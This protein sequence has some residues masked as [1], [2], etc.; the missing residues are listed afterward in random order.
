MS[1]G[2]SDEDADVEHLHAEGRESRERRLFVRL[3][4]LATSFVREAQ[5]R[6]AAVGRHDGE[7]EPVSCIFMEDE[8]MSIF[9]GLSE[10]NLADSVIDPKRLF[11]ALPRP[12]GSPF[13]FPHDIQTEVW[14][15]WFPRRDEPDLVVKMNTGSGK[16]VIGLVICR[17][18]LNEGVGPVA[19]LVPN[20]QLKEQVSSTATLLGIDW[21]GEPSDP[22]F[23]SGE[24]LLIDTVH[25]IFHGRTRFGLRGDTRQPLELGSVVIDDAHACIP[26]IEGQYSFT[27]D[28]TAAAYRQLRELFADVLT[29]QSVVGAANLVSGE[30]SQAVPVPYWSWHERL[31]PAAH[32]LTQHAANSAATPEVKFKWPLIAD[33]LRICDV[34]FGPSKVQIRLPHPDLAAVASFTNAK[35]RVYMTAT[36]AD[37]S[38]LTTSLGVAA[39]CVTEPVTPGSASDLGDRL[40][41]TPTATTAAI[42]ASDVRKQAATWAEQHNVVVIVPSRHRAKAWEE[43]TNEIH[44]KESVQTAIQRLRSGHVGLVVLVARYDGVDLPGPACRVL[45][46]DGLPDSYDPLELVEAVAVGGTEEMRSRQMQ[47]IEQG[48]GRGVRSVDDYCAVLLLDPRLVDRLHH[49]ASRAQLSPATRAQYELSRRFARGGHGKGIDFVRE[50]V[51]AFLRRDPEWVN[52]S[53]AAVEGLQYER[54]DD[55]PAIDEADREGFTLALAGRFEEAKSVLDNAITAMENAPVRGWYKQRGASYLDLINPVKARDLQRSA[56]LDNNYL[57]KLAAETRPPRITALGDQATAAAAYMTEIFSTP[58]NLEL[59]VEAMLSQLTPSPERGSYRGFED[60]V[61]RLGQLLGLASSRPDQQTGVGPDNLWALGNDR[62]FVMEAKS[63]SVATQVS[64]DNLEQLSHSIDWFDD[65][66]S[67]P[68]HTAV[69]ILIHPSRQPMWDARPRQGARVMTFDKLTQLREAVRRF[70][71]ALLSNSDY[72]RSGEVGKNLVQFGLIASQLEQRWTEEFLP[73]ARR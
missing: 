4:A 57:L 62:Y 9:G 69:P 73:P 32:I 42:T 14:D 72:E 12:Q 10:Q 17:S 15:K 50:A 24:A 18:A 36:L 30:G 26:A 66:Y 58:R 48:M 22:R 38:V 19:Y 11:R 37:D 54:P 65:A 27:I 51:A 70:A 55:V 60:G 63:E 3:S 67:E 56:R 7:G 16:T 28:S 61:L 2:Q 68:R 23:Q 13:Q 71:T 29:E 52:A 35:R 49:S 33:Q 21:V 31:Q 59:G 43:V 6:S 39:R 44:D 53:K 1:R 8:G 25:T 46:L 34:A 41:L 47:R 40:I 20:L 5:A 45:I 64:R